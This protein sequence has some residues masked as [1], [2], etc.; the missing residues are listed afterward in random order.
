MREEYFRRL[1]Q[2]HAEWERPVVPDP[3]YDTAGYSE[4][5]ENAE[6]VSA[7]PQRVAELWDAIAALTREFRGG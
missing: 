1:A 5:S 2:I 4:Y 7:P 3:K 6:T